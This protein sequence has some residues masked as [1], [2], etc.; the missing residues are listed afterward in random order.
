MSHKKQKTTES[1]SETMKETTT[2]EEVKEETTN[3]NEVETGNDS[4]TEPTV[5]VQENN[6]F[7]GPDFTQFQNMDGVQE[8]SYGPDFSNLQNGVIYDIDPSIPMPEAIVS[9]EESK[10]TTTE[11]P[12]EE[13]ELYEVTP[14][15]IDHILKNM[16]GGAKL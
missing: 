1:V 3:F 4:N 11:Q 12:Q 16:Q 7:V 10:E 9:E 5:N 13:P 6:V 2:S 8:T 15:D 14:E